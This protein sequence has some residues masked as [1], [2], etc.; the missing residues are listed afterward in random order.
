MDYA[1]LHW[2]CSVLK[3]YIDT[4]ESYLTSTMKRLRGDMVALA[5]I[6][7]KAE[8]PVTDNQRSLETC[9]GLM[10]VQM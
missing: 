10:K 9:P 1:H 5:V 3:K 7:Q 6:V 8:V 2:K 4:N